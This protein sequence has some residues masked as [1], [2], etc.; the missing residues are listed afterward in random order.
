MII[1]NL[2]LWANLQ[3]GFAPESISIIVGINELKSTFFP[4]VISPF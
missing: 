4:S 3:V 1:A 2:A